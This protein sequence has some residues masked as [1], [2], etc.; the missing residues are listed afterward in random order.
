MDGTSLTVGGGAREA[1]GGWEVVGIATSL[2]WRPWGTDLL[3]MAHSSANTTT[4]TLQ[5]QCSL[6]PLARAGHG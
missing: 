1:G 6:L 3:P 5:A 2:G 4:S